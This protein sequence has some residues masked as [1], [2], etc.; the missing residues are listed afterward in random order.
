MCH[1]PIWFPPRCAAE[2]VNG[3]HLPSMTLP[4]LSRSLQ[5]IRGK[6]LKT[7]LVIKMNKAMLKRH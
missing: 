6:P 4:T 1:I 3:L 7:S 2:E 5:A